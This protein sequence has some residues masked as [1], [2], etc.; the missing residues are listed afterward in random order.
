MS[1]AGNWLRD[2][3]PSQGKYILN[4]SLT[5]C[6]GT[7]LFLTSEFPLVLISPRTGVLVNKHQQHPECHLFRDTL[8]TDIDKLKKS[9]RTYLDRSFANPFLPGI[10]PKILVTIDSARHV[11]EELKYR[12]IIDRFMFVVDEFQCLIGDAA[13]K[14]STDLQFL[15]MI[16]SEARNICY[17]S[18]T[19]IEDLYLDALPEFKDIDYYTLDWDP[20]VIIEPTVKEVMMAKGESAC[21][22]F[23]GIIKRFREEG[24]FAK[25]IISG[26]E[27]KSTEAV[28]FINEVKTILKII[29]TNRLR[30]DEVTVLISSSNRYVRELERLGFQIDGQDTDRNNPHNTTFTFCSKA[31]FEGRDFYSTNAFT[32]IFLDGSK[33]WQTH[34]IPIELPQ[35]LGRQRLD[36]NPFRYNAEIYYR[37]KPAVESKEEAIGKIERKLKSSE[38]IITAFNAGDDNLRYSLAALVKGKDPNNFYENNYL[39][40]VNGVS[41]GY[42]LA[43]NFLVAAAE[44]TL[45]SSKYYFYKNPLSL[46]AAIENQMAAFN[47][48]P[49]ELREFERRFNSATTFQERMGCYCG[50]LDSYPQY[51]ATLFENPFIDF[52]YHRLYDILGPHQIQQL[53]YEESA[54]VGECDTIEVRKACMTEF[55]RGQTYTAQQVKDKLQ[56]IY[57]RLG[58]DAV[59]KASLLTKYIDAEKVQIT[60][61]DGSRPRV[62]RIR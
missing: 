24:Y 57:G 48:K 37:I 7:E 26:Q 14:G 33:D 1:A 44:H 56:T 17:M 11:L 38:S 8:K 41:E 28:V 16:D 40:V 2:K 39:E 29:E 13:F 54:I 46:T 32:Y 34:D 10:Q 53:G 12:N 25:K 49:T 23:S 43:I 9:L 5:G 52:K 61:S 6:G 42:S 21:T 45:W 31:S 30:P 36:S 51:R 3:L 62:Y 18:A 22:V 58:I 20:A 35:I 27:V 60:A 47:T 59:A 15:R 4:K 19:P 50:F 55:L